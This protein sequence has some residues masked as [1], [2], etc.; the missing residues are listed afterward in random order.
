VYLLYDLLWL[1]GAM[2][3]V[4]WYLLRRICRGKNRQGLRERFGWYA[5][6]RLDALKGRPVLWLH[7]VSVGE[8]RAAI[9]LIRA[10]KKAFP[11]HALVLTNVTET[12]HAVAEEIDEV[13]LCLFFPFDISFAVRRVLRRLQ[14]EMVVIVETEIWPNLVRC[15][16]R[17]GIPMVLVN[18][19]ISDRSFP[20]YRR[21]R[22]LLQPVLKQFSALCMQTGQDADR[23]LAIGA[24]SERVEVTGNLKFDMSCDGIGDMSQQVL[25]D[26]YKLPLAGLVWVAG[27]TH[28]G[29]EEGILETF[30]AMCEQGVG[31][32]LVLAP[33]H[34]E[35]ARDVGQLLTT[36]GLKWVA[37]TDLD[38]HDGRL[39]NGE[40]LLVDTVGELL[41]LY[42]AADVVFVGG[43]L[44]PVGGH[45]VLEAS[46]LKKPVL[47]GPHMENF[48]EI[49]RLLSEA[50]GGKMVKRTEL[51]GVLGGLL[52]DGQA[53]DAMGRSGYEFL[54]GHAGATERTVNAIRRLL[55]A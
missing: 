30:D 53:R 40:V 16:H 35:R 50:G 32:S 4:P 29:E 54:R 22:S 45:N 24:P 18:G 48:R 12:G 23:I 49:A 26:T 13:D 36:R 37:R 42:A 19:R 2:A 51:S 28:P 27:S 34:P 6:G 44:V 41:K 46:L 14:P 52:A 11:D 39:H 1:I 10:L 15:A 5:P 7:A 47:F 9:S 43:S 33:R 8:T 38:R 17:D 21:V 3:L 25:R 31:L 20:R 55:K